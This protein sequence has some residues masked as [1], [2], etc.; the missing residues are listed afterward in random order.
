M[1][2]CGNTPA[3]A[4]A[5]GCIF[6]IMAFSWLP[7]RCHDAELAEEFRQ[8]K[9]WEY[10]IDLNRT[11]PLSQELALTGEFAGLYTEFEY[12]LRHCTFLWK[13]MHRALLRGGGGKMAIDSVTAGYSHTEHCSHM[14]MTRREVA[15]DVINAVIVVKY[16]DC[17]ME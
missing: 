12:H 14:L 9:G 15:L 4:R 2:P 5:A 7:P 6:D 11:R 1:S 10:F 8:L 13:K 17:G 16:P 3:E